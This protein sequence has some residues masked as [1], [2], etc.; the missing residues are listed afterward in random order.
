M[1]SLVV[2]GPDVADQD[3]FRFHVHSSECGDRIKRIYHN[4]EFKDQWD[5]P[6]ELSSIQDIVTV[7]LGEEIIQSGLPWGEFEDQV[8]IFDCVP[9][10][11]L[12]SPEG[13]TLEW[14]D[15]TP[16]VSP[17]VLDTPPAPIPVGVFTTGTV[18]IMLPQLS[19]ANIK[20][21]PDGGKYA[22]RGR[23]FQYRNDVTVEQAKALLYQLEERR[24]ELESQKTRS[25]DQWAELEALR[26]GLPVLSGSI[27]KLAIA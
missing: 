4:I 17:V 16:E 22:R 26:K 9:P 3:G 27:R 12:E 20:N 5:G 25:Q 10:I 6:C 19:M 1:P 14:D 18:R 15:D 8:R 23:G 7:A 13:T 2:I 21:I 11:P 24:K